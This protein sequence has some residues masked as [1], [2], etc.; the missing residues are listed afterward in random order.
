M[1]FFSDIDSSNYRIIDPDDRET[2]IIREN[3]LPGETILEHIT[4][5]QDPSV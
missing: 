1:T 4:R 3:R 2:D 5:T